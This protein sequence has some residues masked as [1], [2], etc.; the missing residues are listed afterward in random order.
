[1]AGFG[2]VTKLKFRIPANHACLLPTSLMT[3]TTETL[4]LLASITEASGL[5]QKLILVLKMEADALIGSE[6][7]L[8]ANFI[9]AR[10]LFISALAVVLE[11]AGKNIPAMRGHQEARAF[12][13]L[14]TLIGEIKTAPL[15][16]LIEA[17]PE[18]AGYYYKRAEILFN[19]GRDVE[20]ESDFQAV[21]R[22]EPNHFGA[23]NDYGILLMESGSASSARSLFTQAVQDHPDKLVGH[24]NFADFLLSQCEYESAK[25]HYQCALAL[26]PCI[27]KAHQGLAHA[28]A[29]LG[30]NEGAAKHREPGF[31]DQA[32]ISW[33]YRGTGNPVQ[34]LVLGSA[35][36]GNV[37]IQQ[38][39][40]KRSF[41]ASVLLTEYF[42]P[43]TPLPAHSLVINLIGDADLSRGGLDAAE[44]LLSRCTS[45]VINHPA[46]VRPTGRLVNARRL[47]ALPDVRTPRMLLLSKTVLL[48]P[49][50]AKLIAEQ[51]IEF[52]LL[53]RS[54]G[55]HTGQ[56]F[57]SVAS[58]GVLADA[59]TGLPGS[60][61]LVMQLLDASN[62]HG[63][64]HKFRVM[65]VDGELYPLHLA[66]SKHWKVHYFSADM[67]IEP[68]YRALEEQF[69]NDM[70]GLLGNKAMTALNSIRQVLGLDY[71]GIDFA[72]SQNGEVL[73]F[74]ANATMLV[75]QPDN[76]QK[77]AYRQ[78]AAKR[79][80]DAVRSMILKRI[81]GT[82]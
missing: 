74:E 41:Q 80:L 1:V 50:A 29:G 14:Q 75:H 34:L 11:L 37:P 28:L 31:R 70:P 17:H 43:A 10:D 33:T 78:E 72:I 47:A 55:F 45:P 79:I 67:D 77:W 61:L 76:L 7:D 32:N 30:D 39:L 24:I 69:L 5:A 68:E 23:L 53:L 15:D 21:L 56:Y 63:D 36:G 25:Y 49:T 26:D 64:K 48:A 19:L 42:D 6:S 58:P 65:F 4:P 66:I 59:V 73:V 52:P 62:I 13:E 82:R 57:I 16:G 81:S 9:E 22:M 71:G 12:E 51:G 20:A 8:S 44:D 60:D 3:S 18:N 35:F 40:D 54:P 46:L 2:I 27:K 38:I